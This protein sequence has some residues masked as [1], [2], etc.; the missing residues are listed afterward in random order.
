MAVHACRYRG[1]RLFKPLNC[2]VCPQIAT[3]ALR[4]QRVPSYNFDSLTCRHAP[5][6]P[7]TR[8]STAALRVSRHCHATSLARPTG[9]GLALATPSTTR[10]RCRSSGRRPPTRSS[11]ASLGFACELLGQDTGGW[12]ETQRGRAHCRASLNRRNRR[13]ACRGARLCSHAG[14]T[15]WPVT[16]HEAR[17]PDPRWPPDRLERG[18]PAG[19]PRRRR[20][21][22]PAS[23]PAR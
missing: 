10:I 12:P 4:L 22:L 2:S 15:S 5:N 21:P 23:P 1:G 11:R 14:T 8:A 18:W 13:P 20:Q 16:P 3:Y 19:W 17:G 6:S 7:T 9:L